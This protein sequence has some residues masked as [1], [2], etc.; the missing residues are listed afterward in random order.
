MTANQF[1]SVR[2]KTE[3]VRDIIDRM[4]RRTPRIVTLIVASLA[5]LLLFFGW[6]IKYPETVSGR[7]TIR[8][9]QSPVRLTAPNSG[10]LH[11]LSKN[12]EI[13]KAGELIAY[14][15]SGTN[16]EHFFALDSLM[17]R[18]PMDL[19]KSELLETDCTDLGVLTV[20]YLE[21]ATS[22]E[23]LKMYEQNNSFDPRK[24]QLNIQKESNSKM[25][26]FIEKQIEVQ[27]EN[28]K[29]SVR[30]LQKDSVQYF[31]LKSITEVDYLQSK[32]NFLQIIQNL[33]ALE[34]EKSMTE[35]QQRELTERLSQLIAEQKEYEQKLETE[36]FSTYQELKNQ[37]NQWKLKYTFTAPFSGKLEMLNFWKENSF[38]R[39]GEEIFAVLP[40]KNPVV[41]Q[42]EIP[43]NGAGKVKVG[44]EVI[45]KLDD[46]PYLEYGSIT[47]QVKGISMLTNLSE[48]VVQQN[49][50]DS[51]L[52]NVELP[53]QLFTN[54]GSTL[55]FKHDLKGV[56]QILVKKRKLIERL[57][58]NL[59]YIINEP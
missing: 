56:A 47:G 48:D 34:K 11:L 41:A 42:V 5:S 27:N 55:N 8:A 53:K 46:F 36:L 26:L 4:P 59:K 54:Y 9:Q 35:D 39:T 20:A 49:K 6:I 19:L 1:E 37:I 15:E 31:Q 52:V 32:T 29:I 58:D 21:L 23:A 43:A 57:F 38:V 24:E 14:I 33:N 2:E 7:V 30:N 28:R 13:L 25:L 3:E 10:R 12:Q 51:Y 44:Q 50:V 40:D 16:I 45:I 18:N 17:H 22:I